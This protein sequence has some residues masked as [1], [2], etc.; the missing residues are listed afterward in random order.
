[1]TKTPNKRIFLTEKFKLTG[2]KELRN[3][4]AALISL[5]EYSEGI[6]KINT[7]K[8]PMNRMLRYPTR[9]KVGC[10]SIPRDL[11]KSSFANNGLKTP[12]KYA[13]IEVDNRINM[14]S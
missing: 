6:E 5:M 3:K 7:T 14:I 1:M 4:E 12:N 8:S 2:L 13:T 9:L 11:G 10:K